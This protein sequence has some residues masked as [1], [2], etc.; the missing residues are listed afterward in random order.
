MAAADA[1]DPGSADS[2]QA[3]RPSNGLC[4]VEVLPIEGGSRI[5]A[6]GQFDFWTVPKLRAALQ[7]ASR[8]RNPV[9]EVELEEVTYFGSAA[10]AAL[11]ECKH[12]VMAYGGSFKV[13][14]NEYVQEVL[15]ML[16][17]DEKIT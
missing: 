10:I 16:D 4:T 14:A 9:V 5:R 3:G 17:L 12:S 1:N 15:A 7:E 2:D 11:I 8:Q 13:S 6:A